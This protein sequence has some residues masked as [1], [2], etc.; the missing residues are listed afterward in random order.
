MEALRS[1]IQQADSFAS[2]SASFAGVR[3]KACVEAGRQLATLRKTLAHGHWLPW[4][5]RNLKGLLTDETARKW[6][7]LASQV[8][9][10]K[11]NLESAKSIRHA[12]QLAGII[13]DSEESVKTPGGAPASPLVLIDKLGQQLRMVDLDGLSAEQ[14]KGLKK[15]LE[16]VA[17]FYAS[18]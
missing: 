4:L 15:R 10:H 1:L 2:Q 16:P 12:Y 18:L 11:L 7:R 14:R 5:E 9:K 3:I 17:V 8:D 13:P 6:M